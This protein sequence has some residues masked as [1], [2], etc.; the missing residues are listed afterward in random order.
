MLLLLIINLTSSVGIARALAPFMAG[1]MVAL[2]A[3]YYHNHRYIMHLPF[4]LSAYIAMICV[5]I[6]FKLNN[7]INH[8]KH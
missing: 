8:P 6:S 5:L 1:P 4:A 7:S 3:D 2:C